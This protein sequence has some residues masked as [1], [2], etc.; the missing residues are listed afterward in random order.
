M[1][2]ILDL[3]QRARAASSLDDFGD[4]SFREGL[5]RLV[6]SADREARLTERGR[7]GF[8]MQ[9]VD[10]LVNRLQVEHWYRLHPEIDQQQ[11]VAPLIGLGLPRTGSTALSCMLAEDPAVR[12]IRNWEAMTPCPPPQTATEHSDP[13]IEVAQ[14]MV[15][16]RHEMFPRKKAMLPSSATMPTERSE[17]HTSELQSLMRI[18]YAV[19]CLKQNK[20]HE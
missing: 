13:R 14:H 20:R 15:Q 12:S 19:F 8:E 18:S 10:L 2:G 5:E 1:S 9:I 17:E 7:M 11:I 16:R 3:M 4:D 6:E